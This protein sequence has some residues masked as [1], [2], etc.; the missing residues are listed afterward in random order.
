MISSK[1]ATE[2]KSVI[3]QLRS[4]RSEIDEKIQLLEKALGG[5]GVK[6]RGRPPASASAPAVGGSPKKVTRN[7][8]PAARKAAADR[9]RKY[10]AERR[11]GK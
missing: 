1:V 8:S 2:L 5:L 9:M 3:D 10:W 6:R 11:K 7:W 4:E